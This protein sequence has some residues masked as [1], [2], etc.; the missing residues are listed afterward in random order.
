MLLSTAILSW[1]T[2]SCVAAVVGVL[3]PY[4]HKHRHVID[5]GRDLQQLRPRG[6]YCQT[7]RDQRMRY[8]KHTRNQECV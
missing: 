4:Q 5:V 3:V 8:L 7:E 2:G 6:H 1:L